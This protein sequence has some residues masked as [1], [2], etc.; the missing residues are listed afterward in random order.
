MY[1]PISFNVI[2]QALNWHGFPVPTLRQLS[3]NDHD[4]NFIWA[5][6]RAT[7]T[8]EQAVSVIADYPDEDWTLACKNFNFH[9]AKCF[10]EDV[11]VMNAEFHPLK[12]HLTVLFYVKVAREVVAMAQL[13]NSD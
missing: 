10:C 4:L 11:E 3:L 2:R 8:E 12:R 6:Y 7:W 9:L 5:E 1:Q 13:L